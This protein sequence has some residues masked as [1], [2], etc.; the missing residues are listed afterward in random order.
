MV[1]KQHAAACT[2]TYYSDLGLMERDAWVKEVN[3]STHTEGLMVWL[4]FRR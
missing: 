4:L 3:M 2:F 1:S